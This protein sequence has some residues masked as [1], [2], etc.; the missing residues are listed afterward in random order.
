MIKI[1]LT[2]GYWCLIIVTF[3][4]GS[5]KI[6]IVAFKHFEFHI[7]LMIPD[8][9]F[10]LHS[11]MK[12]NFLICLLIALLFISILMR[13]TGLAL[14]FCYL[15]I[16]ITLLN[17][18]MIDLNRFCFIIAM[19]RYWTSSGGVQMSFV[20]FSKLMKLLLNRLDFFVYVL[21]IVL[22]WILKE[23]QSLFNLYNLILQRLCLSKVYAKFSFKLI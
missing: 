17:R 5:T 2:L 11:W 18:K 13:Q 19:R 12:D 6:T 16:P 3:M 15:P 10:R 22:Y 4:F 20:L 7:F 23:I 8:Q 14:L 1:A 21:Q 9:C